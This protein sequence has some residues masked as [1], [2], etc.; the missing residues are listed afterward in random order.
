MPRIIDKPL[1]CYL[2]AQVST[3]AIDT[4]ISVDLNSP[5]FAHIRMNNYLIYINMAAF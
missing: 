4:V 1:T 5:I 3:N 2:H